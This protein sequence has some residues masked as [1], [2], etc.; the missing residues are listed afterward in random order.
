MAP[1]VGSRWPIAV[2]AGPPVWWPSARTVDQR[3]RAPQLPRQLVRAAALQR[4]LVGGPCLE[5]G[6]QAGQVGIALH[7][8]ARGAGIEDERKL[9]V[10]GREAVGDEVVVAAQCRLHV[11]EVVL[12][13]ALDARR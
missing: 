13:L 10:G 8:T 5:P 7:R 1:A 6:M 9:D 2:N 3:V 4:A 11:V 12:E